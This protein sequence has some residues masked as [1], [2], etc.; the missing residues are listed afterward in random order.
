M[1]ALAPAFNHFSVSSSQRLDA[2]D[3]SGRNQRAA[4]VAFESEHAFGLENDY[5]NICHL[6]IF[7]SIDSYFPPLL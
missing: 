5:F 2:A 3:A 1:Q 6:C 4:V 7:K